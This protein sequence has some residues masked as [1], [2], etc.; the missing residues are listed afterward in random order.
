MKKQT[1]LKSPILIRTSASW[2]GRGGGGGGGGVNS[3]HFLLEQT[4]INA[5]SSI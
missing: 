3:H 1:K 4:K 5:S 2:G